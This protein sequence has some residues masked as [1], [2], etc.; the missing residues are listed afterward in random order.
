ME[1]EYR[2]APGGSLRGRLRPPGD[3]SI[4]QRALLLAAVAEGE[5]QLEGILDAA[6]VRAVAQALHA[7]GVPW[8]WRNDTVHV[9]GTGPSGLRTPQGVLDLGNSG[10]GVRLLTGL[11]AGLGLKAI[12]DG[13]HSLRRRPM[14][15]IV[16]PLQQMGARL[17]C[18][19]DGALPLHLEGG[20]TLRGISYRLPVPSAQLKSC[21]LLAGLHARGR[22][23]LEWQTPTRFGHATL[24]MRDHTEN[25]LQAFGAAPQ[26]TPGRVC[27]EGGKKLHGAHIQVPGDLSS[28]AFF[29]VGAC[30]APG[31][32][33]LLE[34]VGINPTRRAILDIL[35]AMG[36]DIEERPRPQLLSGE[37]RCDLRVRATPL[38][39]LR[40]NAP[41]QSA[42]PQPGEL[43][44]EVVA[45]AIDEWP[46]LMIAAACA[47]GRSVLRGA[48]ELRLKESDRL[49]TVAAGLE[50]LGARVR[51]LPDGLELEGG[52]LHGGVVDSQGDHRIAMAFAIAALATDGPV[53]ILNCA[54]VATSFPG[55]AETA[56]RAGLKISVP[57]ATE[58][59]SP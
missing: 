30:I 24:E 52:R 51:R 23:C 45:N 1:I 37:A 20:A 2:V 15:R 44:G 54:S 3:K 55:F 40:V 8:Q 36:A 22:S 59:A 7:L 25:L 18:S 12:L 43:P 34:S 29:L 17:Q 14:R 28:A 48:T 26:R 41:G 4:S 32:E 42:T 27:L 46:I 50:A 10:T 9:Q 21:L 38:R 56:R 47:G 31:S 5:S 33:L 49:E 13:D 11:L 16:A 39:A 35:R 58:R 53:R 57:G 6:D 19:A